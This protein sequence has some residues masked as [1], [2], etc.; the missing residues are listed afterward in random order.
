MPSSAAASHRSQRPHDATSATATPRTTYTGIRHLLAASD[1]NTDG[2]IDSPSRRPDQAG[3]AIEHLFVGGAL[4][5]CS[6][7][8]LEGYVHALPTRVDTAQCP[9]VQL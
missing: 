7:E 4:P 1:I 3:G 2:Y 6:Q 5:A 9:L 8:V